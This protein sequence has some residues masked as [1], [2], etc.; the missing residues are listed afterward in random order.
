MAGPRGPAIGAPRPTTGLARGS[1]TVGAD[2][3]PRHQAVSSTL[4]GLPLQK[5]ARG[6]EVQDL[7]RRLA[8]AGFPVVAPTGEFGDATGHAVTAFQRSR[9]LESTGTCDQPTWAMLVEAGFRLGDRLLYLH[10]PLLR[11]DDVAELQLRL[12]SLGFDAGRVDG[13]FGPDTERALHD[14][15]RNAGLPTDGIAGQ[16]T[17]SELCR[18]GALRN[19][20]EPV[21]VVRERDRLR[22]A[23]RRL[24]GRRV[25]LGEFGDAAALVTATARVL[26]H[27]GGHVLTLHQPDGSAQ[28][29]AAN[30]FGADLY[31]GVALSSEPVCATS[32]FATTGFV[33]SGG[34]RL[35]ELCAERA[36]DILTTATSVDGMRIPILRETRM[37][38]IFCRFGPAH[39]V[40]TRT[41]ALANGLVRAVLTW[42]GAPV[43][44]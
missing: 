38:A 40:I 12:G 29:A 30:Q 33:S 44:P 6:E 1:A 3:L 8:A 32:Y 4:M 21:A 25:V 37:P 17:I 18:L 35:A 7:H 43:A 20:S 31:L 42:C 13:I 23:P 15:Q 19:E 14:F 5:G 24:D 41:P 2:G 9:G 34:Q 16:A 11:G 26:R 10:A 36:Y 28:A 27:A 22:H 39:T